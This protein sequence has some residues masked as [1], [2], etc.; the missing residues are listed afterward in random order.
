[1]GHLFRSRRP[2]MA[3]WGVCAAGLLSLMPAHASPSPTAEPSRPPGVRGSEEPGDLGITYTELSPE[4][5]EQLKAGQGVIIDALFQDRAGYRAGLMRE[6]VIQRLE[7]REIL[8]PSDLTAALLSRRSGQTVRL[9]IVRYGRPLTL[10]VVL[11]SAP[12]RLLLTLTGHQGT[13][14]AVAFAPNGRTLAT[15]GADRTVK[16]WHLRP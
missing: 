5:L 14:N 3:A 4:R 12:L 11:G 1:M 7:G 2:P 15:G 16:L 6:D 13:V 8:S 9:E 10:T